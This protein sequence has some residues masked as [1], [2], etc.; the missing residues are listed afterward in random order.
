MLELTDGYQQA[1]N[2]PDFKH[3]HHCLY[4]PWLLPRLA[5]QRPGTFV[6]I[7]FQKRM[8]RRIESVWAFN[9]KLGYE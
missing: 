8:P 6:L 9:I 5:R 2:I 3:R 1:E 7:I 4:S